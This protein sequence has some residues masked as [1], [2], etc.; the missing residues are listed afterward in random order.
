MNKLKRKGK[1]C[2]YVCLYIYIGI[3]IHV[4]IYIYIQTNAHTLLS[5]LV[6]FL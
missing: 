1:P 3:I 6:E 2:V 4:C 5:C